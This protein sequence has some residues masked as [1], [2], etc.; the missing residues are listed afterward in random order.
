MYM[1]FND[2]DVT[3]YI[4]IYYI[5]FFIYVCMYVY[6]SEEAVYERDLICEKEEIALDENTGKGMHIYIHI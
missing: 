3:I 5:Y 1:Y 4:H 2:N 6:H